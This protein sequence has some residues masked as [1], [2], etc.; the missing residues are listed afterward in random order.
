MPN[1]KKACASTFTSRSIVRVGE[2]A[3][4][5]GA[6]LSHRTSTG[7]SKPSLRRGRY[8]LAEWSESSAASA[9]LSV[10]LAPH[11]ASGRSRGPASGCLAQTAKTTPGHDIFSGILYGSRWAARYGVRQSME[12]KCP[13]G[14]TIEVRVSSR[15]TAYAKN[16]LLSPIRSTD[17][18]GLKDRSP[19]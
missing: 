6:Q 14:R 4:S 17:I 3:S 7:G 1:L 16:G 10:E 15:Q 11:G 12:R 8:R 2:P 9:S 13:P 5:V 18:G 19:E